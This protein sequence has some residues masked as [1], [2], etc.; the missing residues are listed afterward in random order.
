MKNF[1]VT[2]GDDPTSTTVYDNGRPTVLDIPQRPDLRLSTATTCSAFGM[3]N[4]VVAQAYLLNVDM[5]YSLL[6]LTLQLSALL[7][8]LSRAY[9]RSAPTAVFRSVCF[10]IGVVLFI[11]GTPV[12][13]N[14]NS[15]GSTNVLE[16]Q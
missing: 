7:T 9:R 8:V 14:T 2:R 5:P 16:R 6:A 15:G 13:P 12:Q 3:V 1:N 4:G 10:T 11:L